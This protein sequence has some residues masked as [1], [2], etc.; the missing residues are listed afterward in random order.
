MF[1]EIEHPS[2]SKTC[3]KV[4]EI[5]KKTKLVGW[6]LNSMF[7]E[8]DEAKPIVN[9]ADSS[10]VF[11]GPKLVRTRATLDILPAP[12]LAVHPPDVSPPPTGQTSLP[13][14]QPE[15]LLPM[16]HNLHHS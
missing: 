15:Q 9:P 2:G 10:S 11:L 13:F 6:H 14:S 7:L 12:P 5:D 8:E 16:L 3:F 4:A 1:E